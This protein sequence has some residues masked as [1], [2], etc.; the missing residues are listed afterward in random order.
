MLWTI[1]IVLLILWL[2]GF[3][4]NIVGPADPPALARGSG[5]AGLPARQRSPDRRLTPTLPSPVAP[6][7]AEEARCSSA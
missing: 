6:P 1:L 3:A 2:L 7:D 4:T 5:R